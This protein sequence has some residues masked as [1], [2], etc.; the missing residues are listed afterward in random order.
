MEVSFEKPK[1]ARITITLERPEECF[2]LWARLNAPAVVIGEFK[3]HQDPDRTS[4]AHEMFRKLDNAMLK[5][6]VISPE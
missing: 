1:F 5:T 3:H 2:E 6:G 4:T